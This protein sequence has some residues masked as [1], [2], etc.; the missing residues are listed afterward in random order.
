MAEIDKK[1]LQFA[2]EEELIYR[3]LKQEMNPVPIMNVTQSKNE[4]SRQLND[5]RYKKVKL[6]IE[7]SLQLSIIRT[8]RFAKAVKPLCARNSTYLSVHKYKCKI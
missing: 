8:R 5:C 3:M 7:R 1:L 2:K 6:E 4:I